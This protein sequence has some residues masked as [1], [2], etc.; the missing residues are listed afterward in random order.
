MAKVI[1]YVRVDTT[2]QYAD[3]QKHELLEYTNQNH[4]HVDEFIEIGISSR[5]GKVRRR[6]ETLMSRLQPGD[7][8]IV[9]DL[10]GLG[11]STSEVID[12]VN[13]LLAKEIKFIAIKQGL[14]IPSQHD[15]QT[16]ATVSMFSLYA[17]LERDIRHYWSRRKVWLKARRDKEFER[18]LARNRSSL[19][20]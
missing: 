8:L 4:L 1:G 18:F 16:K 17:E 14:N 7:T 20:P 3:N 11:R 9:S 13:E 2:R 19:S 6:I 10:S 5:R 12:I 15:M